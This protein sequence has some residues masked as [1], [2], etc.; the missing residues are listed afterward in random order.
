MVV[1]VEK[2]VLLCTCDLEALLEAYTATAMSPLPH[3]ATMEAS[4]QEAVRA[5]V[6]P[7]GKVAPTLRRDRRMSRL[8]VRIMLAS[9]LQV[10]T[11]AW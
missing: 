1:V 6:T 10:A 9:S 11:R 5:P 8:T 7:P 3:T 2:S 4:G